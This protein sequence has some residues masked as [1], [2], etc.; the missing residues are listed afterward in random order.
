M[1]HLQKLRSPAESAGSAGTHPPEPTEM[2]RRAQ[3]KVLRSGPEVLFLFWGAEVRKD[4]VDLDGRIIYSTGGFLIEVGVLSF[5]CRGV[6][7]SKARR[8][9]K[10]LGKNGVVSNDKNR[11][12]R[13]KH[14]IYC[15]RCSLPKANLDILRSPPS[16]PEVLHPFNGGRTTS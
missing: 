2:K 7:H 13:C 15:S 1:T 6:C 5:F 10:D 11:R 14:Q 4:L 3:Q 9:G 16:F 8:H 12:N